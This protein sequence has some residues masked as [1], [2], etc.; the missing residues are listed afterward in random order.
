MLPNAK[1]LIVVFALAM[2]AFYVCKPICLQYMSAEDF[3]RRRN[4]WLT[5]TVIAFL[6]PSFWL[7]ALFALAILSWAGVREKNPLALY[8]LVTF[9]VPNV[10]FYIPAIFVNQ[11][12]DLTQYRLLAFA[13]LV[14]GLLRTQYAPRSYE[15]RAVCTL[16]IAF[17]LLRIVLLV[18]HESFTNT[19][20]RSFLLV[21]DFL[22]V[23]YAF[24]K[25][26]D[27]DKISEIMASFWM[28]CMIMAPIA[29]FEYIKG[30]LL[31]T[32]L[33]DAWGDPNVFAWLMRGSSLRA[34]AAAGHSIN[35]GYQLAIALGFFMFLKN[36]IA[37]SFLNWLCIALLTSGIFVSLSRGPW[38]T[39]VLIALTFVALR[40]NA[41]RYLGNAAIIS[42]CA[43]AVM[44]VTPLKEAVLDRLPFIGTSGQES[45]DYREQLAEV[46]W[47]LIQQNPLFG[48]P[49]AYRSM[50][51]LR[52]GQGI[53]DIV[54]GYIYTT[55]FTGIVGLSLLV[56]FFLACTFKGFRALLASR[57]NSDEASLMGASLVSCMLG[58]LFYIATA[59]YETT[60]YV[61]CGLLVSFAAAT[62]R[63]SRKPA[64]S[65]SFASV[66]HNY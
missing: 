16:L 3:Q 56:S 8:V 41:T 35:L 51:S 1:P 64:W 30:W 62:A 7:Y 5:L 27:S 53:I 63:T 50:E 26:I 2:A 24:S 61:L 18:P 22:I 6:S 21:T 40:P 59:G 38:V 28:A 31:Y 15:H 65:S 29:L 49:F 66:P 25:I 60:M 19:M 46:S 23:F 48:D 57:N 17:L 47:H 58:S 42:V 44:Y 11:L 37:S 55:L 20:R 9:T 14:P 54:N 13:I 10:Q 45:V 32:G 36:R 12:F 39:A 4:V 52:Q 34:Q 43:F 33:N